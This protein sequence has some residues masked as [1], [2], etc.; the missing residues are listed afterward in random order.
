MLGN[1]KK[2]VQKFNQNDEEL[3][4]QMFSNAEAEEWMSQE[5]P[6]FECPDKTIEEIYYFRWWLFRKHIKQTEEGRII[7]EFL[8]DVPWAGAY[9]SINCASS[10]HLSEARWMKKDQELSKEY[11]NFWFRGSGDEYSY[12]SWI[13]HTIYEHAMVKDDKNLAVQYLDDFIRFYQR[14]ESTHFTSYGLFWSDDDRDAMEKSISGK[15]LRPTL[16]SYMYA[17]ALAIAKISGWVGKTETKKFFEGKAG[18][19]KQN[20]LSMLWD[21]RAQFFKVIPLDTKDS[22]L[23]SADFADIPEKHNAREAIGYIPWDMGIPDSSYD[24]AWRFLM[25]G[26]YF[27]TPFGITT[28][29]KIHSGYMKP[30]DHECLWNGPV[31]PFANTQILNSMI[32]VLQNGEPENI[33]NQDF[34]TL[35]KAYAGSHYRIREDGKKVNWLDEDLDPDTGEWISRKILLEWN[36]REDKG[37]YERGKDYN[38]SAF[39]DLV[40]RGICGVKISEEKK[41]DIHPLLPWGMWDYFMIEDLPYKNHRITIAFDKDGSRYKKGQGLWVEVDG[42]KKASADKASGLSINLS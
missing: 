8:A 23:V 19:L 6:C 36:W 32:R 17:N 4:V 25:D 30:A 40:I 3:I 20:I 12:S 1:W 28:A 37:G 11:I 39:C 10:H 2:Y 13:I 29:E 42:E 22:E 21:D 33:D 18:M 31:W 16:N 24:G 15:G 26:K 14:V 35:M 5:V 41:L 7:T 27:R 34:M 9:N 38:H